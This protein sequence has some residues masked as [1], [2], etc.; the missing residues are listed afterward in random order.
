MLP[1]VTL[2]NEVNGA[3]G[4]IVQVTER[5]GELSSRLKGCSSYSSA[6]HA[7]IPDT[8]GAVGFTSTAVNISA[9]G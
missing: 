8:T 9:E 5:G 6:S 3:H 2:E 4:D 1:E 7:G